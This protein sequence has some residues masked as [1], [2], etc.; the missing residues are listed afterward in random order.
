[1]KIDIKKLK[2]KIR[3]IEKEDWKAMITINFGDFNIKGFRIKTSEFLGKHGEYLWVLPP[4]YKSAFGYKSIIY[5]KKDIWEDMQK[6]I[7]KAY[8]KEFENY[9]KDKMEGVSI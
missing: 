6:E 7:V 2:F 3:I 5:I 8:L 1:M 4:S 9:S